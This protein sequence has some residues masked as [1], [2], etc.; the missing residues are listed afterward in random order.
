[1]ILWYCDRKEKHHC[2]NHQ[3]HADSKDIRKGRRAESHP[4]A[5]MLWQALVAVCRPGKAEDMV[6]SFAVKTALGFTHKSKFISKRILKRVIFKIQGICFS[7]PSSYTCL[8]Y[9][10]C[11][12]GRVP[13]STS[14]Q[15]Q[16]LLPSLVTLIENHWDRN[17]C[18]QLWTEA[19]GKGWQRLQ[20]KGTTASI[21]SQGR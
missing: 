8:G 19:Y 4:L 6:L 15:N 16:S 12:S 18:H 3:Q 21:S 1:M 13:G 20:Q 10:C 5:W 14:A 7:P 9:S 2:H 17:D 11:L